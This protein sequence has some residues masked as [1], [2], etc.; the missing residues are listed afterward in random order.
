MNWRHFNPPTQ[1]TLLL[2]H[3]C[4]EIA[5]AVCEVSFLTKQSKTSRIIGMFWEIV[6]FLILCGQQNSAL[7][8]HVEERGNFMAILSAKAEKDPFLARHL[9]SSKVK[10]TSPEVQNELFKIINI[11]VQ[12]AIVTRCNRWWKQLLLLDYWRKH[13]PFQETTDSLNVHFVE[14][15]NG[16]TEVHKMF[17]GFYRPKSTTGETVFNLITKTTDDLGLNLTKPLGQTYDGASNMKG[18]H[19]GVQVR[20]RQLQPKA[21]YTH[22][23]AHVLNLVVLHNCKEPIVRTLVDTLQKVSFSFSYSAKKLDRY[24]ACLREA[25][26]NT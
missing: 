4:W 22:C 21:L 26:P 5:V 14:Q 11:Q 12:H 6:K 17:L 2:S 20:M 23:C 15:N 7:R 10:Y 8:G 9:A 18:Q 19:K 13:R 25:D 16:L 24:Q 1:L 3:L